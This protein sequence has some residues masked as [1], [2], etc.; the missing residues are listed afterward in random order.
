M[1]H[2]NRMMQIAIDA[3]PELGLR[4]DVGR[5]REEGDAVVVALKSRKVAGAA[6]RLAEVADVIRKATAA[7]PDHGPVLV[8]VA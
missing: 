4:Y 3:A 7:V 6:E 5:M 1:L 8:R 2:T